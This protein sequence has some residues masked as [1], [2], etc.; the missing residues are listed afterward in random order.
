[1]IN[2]NHP[3]APIWV[4]DTKD[5]MICNKRFSQI[6][7]RHHCRRCGW[8]VC[9][10]CSNHLRY[11]TGQGKVKVCNN[12]VPLTSESPNDSDVE[13]PTPQMG[14]K[15]TKSLLKKR[16]S[17]PVIKTALSLSR[18]IKA[19]SKPETK[20]YS[21]FYRAS[22]RQSMESLSP[23]GD[24]QRTGS[25]DTARGLL[26]SSR[27]TAHRITIDKPPE[28]IPPTSETVNELPSSL[29]PLS[30]DVD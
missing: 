30:E 28:I 2:G 11:V 17:S 19:S 23:R 20:S 3:Q 26:G 8:V 18:N 16:I 22:P 29:N 9:N 6:R 10:T 4:P 1:M 24:H 21:T 12:C 13:T 27:S 5:C 7:R 25:L 14:S 15:R